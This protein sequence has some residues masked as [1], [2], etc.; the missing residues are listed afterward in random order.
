MKSMLRI[1]KLVQSVA[2]QVRERMWRAGNNLLKGYPAFTRWNVAR[3]LVMGVLFSAGAV[4]YLNMASEGKADVPTTVQN[5]EAKPGIDSARYLRQ[6]NNDDDWRHGPPAIEKASEESVLAIS[7][8]IS[9]EVLEM[10]Q[11][12]DD[13]WR[14][15]PPYIE[16][17]DAASARPTSP[18][19][20]KSNID[21]MP[22][23]CPTGFPC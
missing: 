9:P 12:I 8:R 23:V 18:I 3:M 20:P 4:M 19:L 21:E 1:R 2:P 5:M 16:K 22:T 7:R 17:I 14:H 13:E 11:R 6:L 10:Y 15:G